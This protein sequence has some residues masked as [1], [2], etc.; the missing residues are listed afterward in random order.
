M[1]KKMSFKMKILSELGLCLLLPILFVL[2]L[3]IIFNYNAI[4]MDKFND[5]E[6]IMRSAAEAVNE[7]INGYLNVVVTAT[8]SNDVK[9]LDPDRVENM[10]LAIM[11][12]YDEGVWSHFLM[13]DADGNEIA[14]SSHNRGN[15]IADREYHYIPWERDMAY[16]CNPSISKSTG[17]KIVPLCAPVHDDNGN[18]IASLVGFVYL[19]HISQVLSDYLMT[20]NSYMIMVNENGLVAA[21]T[22]DSSWDMTVNLIQPG[23]GDAVSGDIIAGLPEDFKNI[24]VNMTEGGTGSTVGSSDIGTSVMTWAPT[25]I[26]ETNISLLMVSPLMESFRTIVVMMAGMIVLTVL[27][28][29]LGIVV[30]LRITGKLSVTISWISDTMVG[31]CNG[32][33]QVAIRKLG[34]QNTRQIGDMITSVT[35]LCDKL[36]DTIQGLNRG[37]SQLTQTAGTISRTVGDSDMAVTDLS[38]IS[39]ELASSMEVVTNHTGEIS[40]RMQNVRSAS[41]EFIAKFEESIGMVEQLHQQAEH[42][43]ENAISGKENAIK[44]VREISD[45]LKNSIEESADAKKIA[46]MTGEILNISGQTNLLSLNASIESARAGESGRGFAVVAEQVRK[47]SEESN[48]TAVKIQDLSNHVIEVVE[49][50]GRDSGQMLNFMG[51]TVVSDYNQFELAASEYAEGMKQVN[52]IMHEFSRMAKE[53]KEVI[54][55]MEAELSSI[56]TSISECSTGIMN[57]A[58]SSTSLAQAMADINEEVEYNLK[59]S[60]E[61]HGQVERLEGKA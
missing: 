14:H 32:N 52:G 26:N 24:I 11:E 25:G 19:D 8:E 28:L 60:E 38:A 39:E 46:D 12:D 3:L 7:K 40:E 23:E 50:L 41:E 30:I 17:N 4:K 57:I 6:I 45:A 21:S 36:G 48:T 5:N 59:I 16:V 20:Q 10:M 34:Y 43:H 56:N 42:T 15:N 61:L 51:D 1:S 18:V 47:L 2:I 37:S 33:T 13:T 9:S 49:R 29:L 58:D 53:L 27:I 55:E 44:V 35:T 22:K 54:R 31:L